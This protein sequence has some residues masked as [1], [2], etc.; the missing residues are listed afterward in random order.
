MQHN[1]LDMIR[2][3]IH[4]V[5][6][7]HSEHYSALQILQMMIRYKIHTVNDFHSEHYSAL[8]IL[9]MQHNVL[10]RHDTIQNSHAE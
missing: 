5:N 6:D 9:Q 3:K 2:Y 10:N 4:T 1:L 7:F 8:Q